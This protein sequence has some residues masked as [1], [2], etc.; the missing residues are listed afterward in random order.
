MTIVARGPSGMPSRQIVQLHHADPEQPDRR[1]TSTPPA[2]ACSRTARTYGIGMVVV[3][4]F[5]EPIDNKANAE[6]HLV[7]HHEPAGRRAP[8]TGSTTRPRTG[9]PRSTTP[10]AHPSRWTANLYG[11]AARRR[12]LRRGGRARVV[13]DRR[14]RTSRSPT[15]TPSR[16]AS[17]TTASW[18]APC[19]RRWAWA[20]P[21][22][23]AAPRCLLDAARRLHRAG[24]GQPGDHGLLDVRAADQ[25]PPRLQGDH[26][27][28]HP[29]QHRRHLPAPAQLDGV[30]AG[31]HR[32][33]RTAA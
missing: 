9:G 20:A 2:A 25:L 17:S 30:G 24:Q 15:T 4:H 3:A 8:G 27:L 19:R 23:S 14:L 11:T 18:S 33:L 26:R 28:G 32:H 31:Q 16:S 13:Q 22:R 1:S 21:R 7:R 12:A 5:D 6:R 10:Q 29:D